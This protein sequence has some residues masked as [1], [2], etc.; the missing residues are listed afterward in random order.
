MPGCLHRVTGRNNNFECVVTGSTDR[1]PTER[2][3]QVGA[4]P[5]WIVF[6]EAKD[7][8][9]HYQDYAQSNE[10]CSEIYFRKYN[11]ISEFLMNRGIRSQWQ[12]KK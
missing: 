9:S 4:T 8:F 10:E 12:I 7:I 5:E 11:V 1:K 2:E 6:D 3:I